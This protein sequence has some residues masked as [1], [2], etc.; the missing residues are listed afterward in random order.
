M[1]PTA[2]PDGSVRAGTATSAVGFGLGVASGLAT[3]ADS[4]S[5]VAEAAGMDDGDDSGFVGV[6]GVGV[7]GVGIDGVGVDGDGVGGVGGIDVESMLGELS[8]AGP[9]PR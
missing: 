8:G 5:S 1:R 7:D 4:I 2:L 3:A 6:D 9:S